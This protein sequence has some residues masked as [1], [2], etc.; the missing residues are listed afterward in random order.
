MYSTFVDG[1]LLISVGVNL[2]VF[3]E[4]G[5]PPYLCEG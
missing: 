4:D 2:L 3:V 5:F 1:G